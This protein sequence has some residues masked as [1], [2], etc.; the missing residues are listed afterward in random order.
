[1]KKLESQLDDDKPY[2]KLLLDFIDEMKFLIIEQK[3]FIE[4][5]G[6]KDE[7]SKGMLGF[8]IEDGSKKLKI[9][10]KIIVN[11]DIKDD[12]LRRFSKI[13]KE[14]LP[15]GLSS[16][17]GFDSE[18]EVINQ[19]GE[20]IEQAP[21][22]KRSLL[23][24]LVFASLLASLVLIVGDDGPFQNLEPD[25]E[26]DATELVKKIHQTLKLNLI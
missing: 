1:M 8:A 20:L 15:K 11:L 12:F 9:L 19:E 13:K 18:D 6:N 26:E 4:R 23:K 21:I 16:S 25:K 14:D 5:L 7:Q 3:S 2:Y 10:S 17:S 22:N 24:K